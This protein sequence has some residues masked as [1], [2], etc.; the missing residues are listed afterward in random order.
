[1]AVAT[2]AVLAEPAT[3]QIEPRESAGQSGPRADAW[4]RLRRDGLT[5]AA[6]A[7]LLSILALAAAADLLAGSVFH[8]SS[9]QQD[10]ANT[11]ARPDFSVPALWLGTDEIGRSQA[12]R[13]LYGARV[14]LAVGFGAA[15]LNLLLGIVLGLAAGYFGGWVDDVVQYLVSTLNS[16]PRLFLLLLFAVLFSP[17]PVLLIVVL[18]VLAW[19]HVALFVRG[20]TL[21][22]RER[23]FVMAAHVIGASHARIM[24]RQI[25][26]NSCPAGGDQQHKRSLVAGLWTFVSSFQAARGRR[27]RAA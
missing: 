23:E 20:Q 13:L 14:S 16:I 5:L 21:S 10:L 4:R 7:L 12:V 25:L 19:P 24:F 15:F 8:Y 17:G 26:P 1:M 2:R 11:Y 3:F 6:L 18:A 22:L 9:T 27:A